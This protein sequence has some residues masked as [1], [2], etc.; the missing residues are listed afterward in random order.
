[1]K[2]Q[3]SAIGWNHARFIEADDF[4]PFLWQLTAPRL[5]NF[6]RKAQRRRIVAP[7]QLVTKLGT[8]TALIVNGS[9]GWTVPRSQEVTVVE[10]VDAT[11][12][13]ERMPLRD[14]ASLG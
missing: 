13:D 8:E 12:V 14:I 2:D 9:Q 3:P 4:P 1:M 10:V 6:E 7:R 5:P 11:F